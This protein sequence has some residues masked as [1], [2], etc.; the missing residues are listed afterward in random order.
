LLTETW[1]LVVVVE[2]VIRFE[3]NLV[4]I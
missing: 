2:P 1:S 4:G 3:L